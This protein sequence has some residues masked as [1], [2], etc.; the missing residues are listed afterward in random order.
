MNILIDASN[1]I[2]GGGV[3]HLTEVLEATNLET[4]RLR[5][6]NKV[7]V[8]G[9]S[10]TLNKL[11]SKGWLTMIPMTGGDSNFIKR[12]VWKKRNF[13]RLFKEKNID[14]VFNPGGS[15]FG[16]GLPYITMC[17][18]MLVFETKEANRY[19]SVLYRSKFLL[20][21]MFQ[22]IS[23]KRSLGTIFISE[24]AHDYISR[25]YPKISLKNWIVI[26]H[27]VS[28]R[29]RDNIKKQY[30]IEEYSSLRPF[31]ILYVSILDVYKHHDKIAEAIVKLNLIDTFP[32]EFVVVGDKAGGYKEFEEVRS[33]HPNI[34]K[35]LGK[36][37]FEEIQAHYKDADLFVYGSTCENMP[38]ILIEAMSSGV[39]IC[40]SQKQPMPEFLRDGGL[41]FD[42]EDPDSIYKCLKKAILDEN[43]RNEIAV[44]SNKLSKKYSW[45]KCAD[46]TFDFISI[47][48]NQYSENK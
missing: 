27:G 36:V 17:R 3:S 6:I 1:I 37:P 43:L 20:L 23:M 33:K 40:C 25:F 11:P 42:A 35:Y 45:E 12:F 14:I 2:S 41:Y 26:N 19:D 34:I 13:K 5:D 10:A 16:G 22:S 48:Y 28:N 32:V 29:F 46:E 15:Y 38:N 47:C 8:V 21:R 39:P 24:Y 18:N 9:V 30:K 4:L 44:T 31:K 7:Y